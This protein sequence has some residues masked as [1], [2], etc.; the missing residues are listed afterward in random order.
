[1]IR[2][3]RENAD[4]GVKVFKRVQ[5]HTNLQL[6]SILD[7][8]STV[9]QIHRRDIVK[10]LGRS[11]SRCFTNVTDLGKVG[12]GGGGTCRHIFTQKNKDIRTNSF[13]MDLS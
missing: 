8:I 12:D 13:M 6:R 3:I 10:M 2:I 9:R 11:I 7:N 1:M 5:K 4:F